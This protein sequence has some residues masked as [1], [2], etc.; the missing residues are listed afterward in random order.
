MFSPPLTCST[1]H[2]T[3][4][5]VVRAAPSGAQAPTP[6]FL[7]CLGKS[8]CGGAWRTGQNAGGEMAATWRIWWKQTFPLVEVRGTDTLHQESQKTGLFTHSS[9]AV[10]GDSPGQPFLHRVTQD[11]R[12]FFRVALSS[13]HWS[14]PSSPQS[15]EGRPS[16][17][18]P[19][20]D[21]PHFCSHFIV[22]C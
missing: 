10:L 4:H 8:R 13:Q 15:R 1:S 11:S 18:Q 5:P 2:P 6:A 19:G 14:P 17:P 7:E 12:S 21:T 3:H 9:S 20:N 22:Q 16:L